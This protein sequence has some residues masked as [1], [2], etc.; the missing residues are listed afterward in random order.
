M[1]LQTGISLLQIEETKEVLLEKF[2]DIEFIVNI[3]NGQ[4]SLPIKTLSSIWIAVCAS[5]IG[6]DRTAYALK[7]VRQPQG[8]V[9]VGDPSTIRKMIVISFVILVIGVICNSFVDFDFELDSLAAAFGFSTTL[10]I[11]GQKAIKCVKYV[12]LNGNGIPDNEETEDEPDYEETE[13]E[14]ADIEEESDSE[15]TA[16]D[17]KAVEIFEKASEIVKTQVPKRKRKEK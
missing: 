5:Y 6:V 3:L 9:D 10:Y 11:T 12:D 4:V 15:D 2:K 16:S 14:N 1:L 17:S 13:I 8:E 7:S